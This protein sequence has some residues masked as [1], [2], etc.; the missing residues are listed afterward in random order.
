MNASN[1]DHDRK[2]TIALTL[3]LA[4][5]FSAGQFGANFAPYLI[6]ALEKQAGTTP[7]FA[8]YLMSIEFGALF[9]SSLVFL[10]WGASW[11][12]SVVAAV[13]VGAYAL[14]SAA[15][16]FSSDFT[17]LAAARALCGLGGG[18][19][20]AAANAAAAS[21]SNY[22]EAFVRA[23]AGSSLVAFVLY[24]AVPFAL[25]RFGSQAL[26]LTLGCASGLLLAPACFLSRGPR[27]NPIEHKSQSSILGP[28]AGVMLGTLLL[29]AGGLFARVN[30]GISWSFNARFA[31]NAHVD[32]QTLGLFLG[33]LTLACAAAPS[34]ANALGQRFGY[35][36]VFLVV[37]MIKA[38]ATY[39]LY[40]AGSLWLFVLN[41]SVL[42]FT[43]V[44][45]MQLLSGALAAR[46]GTGRLAVIGT[47]TLMV[48]DVFGPLISG[49]VYQSGGLLGVTLAACLAAGIAIMFLFGASLLGRRET[50]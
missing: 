8:G 1:S 27:A 48:G 15:T 25:D 9:L 41:Q 36:R 7:Q 3:A 47:M 38:V 2:I 16:A 42:F 50:A 49:T 11:P 32:Y 29:L 13:G 35:V 4:A 31:E 40:T 30:D 10:R 23:I 28:T 34:G 46:D 5:S 6:P 14:G 22:R 24:S 18:A 33:F 21:H 44:M 45:I 43:F 26:F 17:Q 37:M 39:G 12:L 20:L 19:A